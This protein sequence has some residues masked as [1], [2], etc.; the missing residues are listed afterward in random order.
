MCHQPPTSCSMPLKPGRSSLDPDGRTVQVRPLAL[1]AATISAAWRD[2]FESPQC[3][4][5]PRLSLE[6][7]A[8]VVTQNRKQAHAPST[9]WGLGKMG[10]RIPSAAKVDFAGS[11]VER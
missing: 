4:G 7:R 9:D 1:L 6:F 3:G 10:E 2:R 8:V 5:H 11:A